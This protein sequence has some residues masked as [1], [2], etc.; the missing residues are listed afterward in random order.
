MSADL[1]AAKLIATKYARRNSS[2]GLSIFLKDY[3]CQITHKTLS[4]DQCV[5]II[6]SV[7][8]IVEAERFAADQE[9]ED[10]ASIK[11]P[12]AHVEWYQDFYENNPEQHH[13]WNLLKEFLRVKFAEKNSLKHAECALRSL[14]EATKDILSL[15]E[16]PNG[17]GA[18]QSKGLVV[19]YVQSGKT[20]NFSAVITKAVDAGYK[21]IIVLT[22]IH[23]ALRKQTQDR[24]DQELTGEPSLL[25]T[26]RVKPQ[27][28]GLDEWSRL[29]NHLKDFDSRHHAHFSQVMQRRGPVLAVIKKNCN[30][31]KNIFLWAQEAP[32]MLRNRLPVLVIDDE[33]DLASIDT[34]FDKKAKTDNNS[35]SKTNKLIREVLA[36]F[37]R[38][39]Y[40]GYTATPFAIVNIK[41]S[42]NQKELKRD[43][44]P[45]NF[46]IKL[47]PPADYLNYM[48]ASHIFRKGLEKHYLR[49]VSPE[50]VTKLVGKGR[51]GALSRPTGPTPKLI[52]AIHCFIL[53]AAARRS[54]GDT[55]EPTSMLIHTSQRQ[56]SHTKMKDVV[57]AIIKSIKTR[58]QDSRE[59]IIL[60]SMLKMLWEQD[61][62][63]ATNAISK[64]HKSVP[65]SHIKP[66]I[67]DLLEKIQTLELN[68]ASDDRLTYTKGLGQNI[69]AIGGNQLSR[70]L[71]IQGLLVSFYCRR[72]TQYDTLLQMGRWFGY[73]PNYEDLVR[74]YTT[75]ELAEW[76]RHLSTVEEDL[77]KQ[78][79]EYSSKT[80]TPMDFAPR[81]LA[82]YR[83][84]IT[85]IKK[86]G[87]G[88][89]IGGF[90]QSVQSTYWL[91]LDKPGAL[92]NNL[93]WG[94]SFIENV[95]RTERFQV[96]SGFGGYLAKDVSG[97][98]VLAF[99]KKYRFA[100]PAE[101]D[102]SGLDSQCLIEYIERL[103]KHGELQKWNIGL[104]VGA[105]NRNT[106]K[107]SYMSFGDLKIVKVTR[108]QRKEEGRIGY[109]VGSM[110]N[111][112]TLR[113][114]RQK[115]NEPLF[116][117]GAPAKPLLVLYFVD[118]ESKPLIG[119][120]KDKKKSAH[121]EV[122]LF[123][124]I[125]KKKHRDVL[126]L[127][128]VFPK[129][130]FDGDGYVG[131]N[132]NET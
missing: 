112:A 42:T 53:A 5:L 2:K 17:I 83:M 67:S 114:D 94:K 66:L 93:K 49:Y 7:K 97:T 29:T 56:V 107:S 39:S 50:E 34:E 130:I 81:I 19:G 128:F 84:R 52:E 37:D 62:I 24:L 44:Y 41:A 82:H 46:I 21:L 73:R 51:I 125:S 31:L 60:H 108:N 48:G 122:A 100:L 75:K 13:R 61:F 43:L 118:K 25:E 102:G 4:R 20:A 30:V 57:D 59:G 120:S 126:G 32:E 101:T 127:G 36:L 1:E 117:Q 23:E 92:E 35:P 45:R 99:L 131:Q 12:E 105:T 70:G 78:I 119:L 69:I 86:M 71:T 110:T 124:G 11:N 9:I 40:I 77:R 38:H 113:L 132:I 54:R 95:N 28:K 58:I 72:S 18:F 26:H 91:P 33:A 104:A 109:R 76:F 87:V 68:E 106:S 96:R 64:N 16:N 74:I 116:T 8:R 90:A 89:K 98:M 115:L 47:P 63:P 15:M 80:L 55:T 129:S 111:P 123:S 14:D 85:S 3:R 27:Q 88:A 65:Y 79:D 10:T 121:K 6:D 103:T 22:G